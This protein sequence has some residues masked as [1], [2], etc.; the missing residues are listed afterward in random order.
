MDWIDMAQNRDMFQAL[1][2]AV[3]QFRVSIKYGDFLTS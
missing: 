3:M 1:V 2:N